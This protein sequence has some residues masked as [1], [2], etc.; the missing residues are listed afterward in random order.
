M[1]AT[2]PTPLGDLLAAAT[3]DGLVRCDFA[4]RPGFAV[5]PTSAGGREHLDRL[6]DEMAE[7]FAGRRTTFTVPLAAAAGTPFQR[8]A[9]AFLSTIPFGQTR[10]YGQQAAAVG[11]PAA[12]RAVGRANGA[13]PLCVVVPC[14]RVV[15][16]TGHLTGFG[17]GLDRKRR[18]LDHERA[19]ATVSA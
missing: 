1:I 15:G 5:G 2:I 11:S 9:W 3:D 14:H 19:V 12:A 18:L 6:R 16:G 4:D 7:Y 17:G 10:T 8:A 13:N